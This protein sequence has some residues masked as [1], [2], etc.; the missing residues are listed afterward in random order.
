[1]LDRTV[2][3]QGR[4]T[5]C[6]ADAMASDVSFVVALG[7]SCFIYASLSCADGKLWLV[8]ELCRDG[9]PEPTGY[10]REPIYVAE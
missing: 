1:M 6:Q 10:S 4:L 2:T 5:Q 7:S 9:S 3:G 8:Y